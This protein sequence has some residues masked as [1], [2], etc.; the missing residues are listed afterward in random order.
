MIAARSLANKS[1]ARVASNSARFFS[2]TSRTQ[3]L[4]PSDEQ[5]AAAVQ[6]QSPNR[7]D[8][9]AKSQKPRSE[10]LQGV[11][12]LQRNLEDQ[13]QPYAAI[14][15][16]SQTPIIYLHENTA[17]CDGGKGVQGHPK[18]YINLDKPKA[19]ACQY[20]GTRYANE[21]FKEE[22]EAAEAKA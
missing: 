6:K 10:A 3:Y 22:I 16:I 4:V 19:H 7:A 18:I 14:N 8:T 17:V 13:P 9:W 2:V 1:V 11:R 21:H 20:C 15:L 12:T 5:Q